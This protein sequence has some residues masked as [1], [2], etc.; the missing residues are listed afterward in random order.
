LE[1][2]EAALAK[3]EQSMLADQVKASARL[4][5]REAVVAE[6]QAALAEGQRALAARE[7]QEQRLGM[8]GATASAGEV[9]EMRLK[10]Q[11]LASQS[12]LD[13]VR[14]RELE[15]DACKLRASVE[16]G[17]KD[18][19]KVLTSALKEIWRGRGLIGMI[20]FL[21]SVCDGT[22]TEAVRAPEYGKRRSKNLMQFLD[23]CLNLRCVSG[24]RDQGGACDRRPAGTQSRGRRR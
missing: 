3:R 24:T 4:R 1:A 12:R 11:D 17:G 2:R 18:L 10:M 16:K 23:E 13:N 22:V 7:K 14:F 9:A 20:R 19:D 8:G 6:Q 21:D 15:T 5:A